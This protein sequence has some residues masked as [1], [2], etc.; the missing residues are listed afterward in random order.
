[1][2]QICEMKKV[3][4]EVVKRG[5]NELRLVDGMHSATLLLGEKS[6]N[7]SKDMVEMVCMEMEKDIQNKTSKVNSELG[8]IQSFSRVER[9]MAVKKIT[10]EPNNVLIFWSLDESER[11]D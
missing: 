11:E 3:Q 8:K 5:K 6:E 4:A 7:A 10:S 9:F 1:M 2:L